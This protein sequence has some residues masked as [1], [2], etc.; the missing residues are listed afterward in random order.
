MDIR[1]LSSLI[2]KWHVRLDEKTWLATTI[3]YDDNGEEKEEQIPFKY[4]I[5]NTCNG[6]GY[7]V[8]P[9]IDSHG[10][11]QEEGSEEWGDSDRQN[12]L[13]GLYDVPCRN[14]DGQRV[15]A[16]IDKTRATEKQINLVNEKIQEEHDY[17]RLVES[18]RR[19]GC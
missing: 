4:T 13:E 19:F 17:A 2:E 5:C 16:I 1:I 14:C 15:V 3:V 8:N 7:Y 12:Y 9:N 10:I 11:T 6:T 18:E